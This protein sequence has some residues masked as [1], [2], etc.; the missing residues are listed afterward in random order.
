MIRDSTPNTRKSTAR[1]T[2]TSTKPKAWVRPRTIN[3]KNKI[4]DNV[5]RRKEIRIRVKEI[6]AELNRRH[7]HQIPTAKEQ[8]LALYEEQEEL[9]K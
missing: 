7:I 9:M 8:Y 3:Q 5:K 4:M 2:S 1:L 6:I